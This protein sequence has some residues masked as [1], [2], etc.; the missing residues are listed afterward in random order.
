VGSRHF[1][2]YISPRIIAPYWG[3]SSHMKMETA[4]EIDEDKIDEA[5]LALFYLTLH[6]SPIGFMKKDIFTI[7]LANLSLLF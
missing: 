1:V 5:A 7:L 4:V 3:G 2:P 6:E